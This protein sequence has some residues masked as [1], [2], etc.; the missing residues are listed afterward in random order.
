MYVGVPAKDTR[1]CRCSRLATNICSAAKFLAVRCHRSVLS[2]AAK[3][4]L[5]PSGEPNYKPPGSVAMRKFI[6]ALLPLIASQVH[7]QVPPDI[8]RTHG[9]DPAVERSGEDKVRGKT[10]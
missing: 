9:D 5:T 2:M 10:F 4:H 1:I 8:A 7:S 3:L 6:L